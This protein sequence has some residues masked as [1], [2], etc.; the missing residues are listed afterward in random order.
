MAT[1][2]YQLENCHHEYDSK[3]DA[4]VLAAR[5]T[6][7]FL[8]S[9]K[10]IIVYNL[11]SYRAAGHSG[12]LGRPYSSA[13]PIQ[14]VGLCYARRVSGVFVPSTKKK[15][16]LT[17][18]AE[19]IDALETLLKEGESSNSRSFERL[20]PVL[21]G[22][23]VDCQSACAML[24]GLTAACG[25]CYASPPARTGDFVV[26]TQSST[27]WVGEWNDHCSSPSHQLVW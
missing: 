10:D 2:S 22:T 8:D 23:H 7:A 20:V 12:G 25:E 15:R 14:A 17:A 19:I 13:A 27:G 24:L 4:G 3:S 11:D 6:L 18:F 9:L 21:R 16:H 1:V 26:F 5:R